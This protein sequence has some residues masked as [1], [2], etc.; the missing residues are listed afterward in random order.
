MAERVV[1]EGIDEAVDALASLD[2][3]K[4]MR[5]AMNKALQHLQRRIAKYP[6]RPTHSTYTRT[7]TL[8]RRWTSEVT[9]R[10][11]HGELGNNTPYA[12]F[13]QG[14]RRRT[15]H[16]DA[17]WVSAQEVADEESGEVTDIFRDEYNRA[18]R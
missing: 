6:A 15:F 1:I 17:G 5:R 10:G 16:E 11:K 13:V 8:G 12:I 7:G 14:S 18:N 3:P 9:R 2:D 4:I